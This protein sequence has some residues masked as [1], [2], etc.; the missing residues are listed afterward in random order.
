[1]CGKVPHHRRVD[2]LRALR[3]LMSKE[4]N[5]TNLVAACVSIATIPVGMLLQG[6]VLVQLWGWF[7]VPLGAARLNLAQ[8]IGL[9]LVW[10]IVRGAQVQYI[11]VGEM[12]NSLCPSKSTAPEV[13]Q[14]R[15]VCDLLIPLI[16]WG[17]GWVVHLFL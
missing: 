2:L 16:L 13:C 15:L 6:Y 5:A 8:A 11:Q 4:G 9:R 3:V 1:M 10:F 17:A 12:H 7:V 14:N